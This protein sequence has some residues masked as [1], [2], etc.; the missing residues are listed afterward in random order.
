MAKT[1]NNR[2]PESEMRIGALQVARSK[3]NGCATTTEI[4]EEIG[5]FV[6]LTS[7]DMVIS[8][9]RSP[10]PMYCQIVGNL[11]SHRATSSRSLFVRGYATRTDDGLCIT[12]FGRQYLARLGL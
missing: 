10:E 12:D 4:K 9:T 5:R 2:T 6:D 1:R 11:V 3:R 8:S 7:K